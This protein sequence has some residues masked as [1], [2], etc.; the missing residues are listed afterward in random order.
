M[1]YRGATFTF[2]SASALLFACAVDIG[3]FFNPPTVPENQV[4]FNGG[5]LGLITPDLTKENELIAFRIL[6]GLKMDQDKA[7]VGERKPAVGVDAADFKPTGAQAWLAKRKTIADPP[8]PAFINSYRNSTA[9][10]DQF[11]YYENCLDDG[12][13]TAAHTLDDR[14][15]KYGSASAL[16]AWVTAQ[17]Q[18]FSN[19]NG[20]K[21]DYPDALA[22]ATPLERA[23]RE[24]QIAAAHFYAE[25]FSEAKRRFQTIANDATSPWRNVASYLV[26]RTLLRDASLHN[27]TA[28]L[29]QA[30]EELTKVANNPSAAPLNDSARKLLEHLDA[31]EHSQA[32]LESLSTRLLAPGASRPSVEDAI[33]Q[34]AFVLRATSFKT[35]LSKP[36]IPEAFD[37][38]Q[39]LEDGTAAHAV[40][41]WRSHKSL[42]WLTLALMYANGKDPDVPELLQQ[43]G[44]LTESSPAFGTASYNDVRLLIEREELDTAR[45][46][47]DQLLA[48]T[49]DQ[50]DSLVNGWRAERMRV[51]TNF[52]DLLR[53]AARRP[54]RPEDYIAV[55]PNAGSE[56]LDADSAYV[57][58]NLTPL[59]KLKL[60]A[61]STLLPA[62]SAA[63][64]AL[65]GWTR[66]L[67][68]NDLDTVRDLA[69]IV[70]KAHP[71]WRSTLMPAADAQ[72]DH[73]KFQAA[74]LIAIHRQFRPTVLVAYRTEL[75]AA[76]GWWCP[77]E[78]GPAKEVGRENTI[79]W[80]LPVIF[81]PSKQALSQ[82]DLDAASREIGQLHE[83]GSTEA[84]LAPII[85]GWAKAHPD[86]AQ[87]PQALHRLVMVTRYG[88]RNGDP[89][90]GQISK[91][92]F[93]VLHNQYPKD[94]WTARTPYWFK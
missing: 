90:T 94:P 53:W 4:A 37:W 60:A 62:W 49:K 57:F 82:E 13:E 16:K 85:M 78:A 69:P 6:S 79:A 7:A 22:G 61:H 88:C 80:H 75:D 44:G 24:Y 52:D 68:L 34:S 15:A 41:A 66:A 70:A 12:F 54:V 19:C 1:T 17:D 64:V 38:V 28:A 27:N 33:D 47:L 48:R 93:D 81:S 55:K 32:T 35:A 29:P 86:D 83:K 71:D 9:A 72:L 59:A 8:A 76:G 84:F 45:Q 2:L 56:V 3:P 91:A 26:A 25:D 65:A 63:D 20:E 39:T 5:R 58:N 51:A 87:V 92:A 43:A 67:M 18:V 46:R 21:A 50:P 73:W 42:P 11:V 10:G 36:E 77:V 14:R 23:D 74:L 40:E 89:S 31:I 30:R